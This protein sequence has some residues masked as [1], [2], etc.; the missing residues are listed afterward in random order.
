MPLLAPSLLLHCSDG[1]ITI[2]ELGNAYCSTR[3]QS[4]AQGYVLPLLLLGMC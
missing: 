4:Y 3:W 2:I 1:I